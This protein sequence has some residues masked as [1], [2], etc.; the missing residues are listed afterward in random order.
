MGG[1]IEY[2]GKGL[3]CK[4]IAKYEPKF[5][6]CI[7][8]KI[9]FSEKKWVI[10]SIYRPPNAENLTGFFEEMTTSLTKVTSNYE[11]IIVM[12][13]FNIDIK[14]KSVGSNNL[15]DFCDL[16]HLTN[17]VKSDTCF[18]KTH[19]SLIDLILTNKPS[20]FNKTLV[21][22]TGLSD[23]HKMITT[24]F[25][26]HFSRLR[27]KVITYRNYKKFH[28]E[29]FLNDLKETNIIMNEKDPNQNYQSLTKTFLT[30][31]NKHA[32]LKKKIVRGNQAPFMTKEFQKAIYTRSRLKNKMNKNPTEKNITAY[33]RQRNL[34]VSLRRKNIKSFLKNVTKRSIIANKNFWTFI[35]PFLI[36]KGFLENNDITLIE[37]NNIITS[38]RE[39]VKTFNEHYIKIDEKSSGDKN[40]NIHKI[41]REIVKFYQNHPSILQI[42]N[43]CSTSF[44]VKE[45][46]CFQFVN[47]IEI[48]KLI[49]GLNSKKATGIDTIPP[50]LMKVA[51]DFLTSPLTKSINSNIEHKIFHD[52]AKTPLVVHL[53]KENL[54]KM[55]LQIFDL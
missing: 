48:N 20:S 38:E 46:F 43:I 39:L 31:V 30:I 8:P 10:S 13:D 27:P 50:K 45:K 41:I 33:K 47:E 19:T 51:V 34:C 24:F 53:I 14:C 4:R 11:N 9:T 32:P 12:G 36:N 7:C 40:Q 23:Y 16:F 6:E 3:I 29:K 28:E 44:H 55:I 52:L 17:I 2:V 15:S 18:T 35:K 5:N 54:I 49:Q 26:L 25:K 42:K 21:S 22:E 37:G 1:L